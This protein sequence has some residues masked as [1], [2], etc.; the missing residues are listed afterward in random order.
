[1]KH[2]SLFRRCSGVAVFIGAYLVSGCGVPKISPVTSLGSSSQTA[3]S[4]SKTRERLLYSFHGT[5]DGAGPAGNLIFDRS[6]ALYGTT[7]GGGVTYLDC[8]AGCGTVFKL[9]PTGSGYAETILYRFLGQKYNDGG[10]SPAGGLTPA[11]GGVVFGTTTYGGPVQEGT[12]FE[13]APL[14]TGYLERV[15]HG[16]GS[17]PKDGANPFAGMTAGKNGVFYGTTFGGGAHGWGTVFALSPSSSG[18]GYTESIVYNFRGG[19]RDGAEPQA[20]V[21]VDANGALYGTTNG[22]GKFCETSGGACGTVFKLTPAGSGYS[23]KV[24]HIFRPRKDGAFPQSALL[25]GKSRALYGTTSEWGPRGDCGTIFELLPAGSNYTFRVLHVFKCSNGGS[26][27]AALIADR[28][29]T[30]FGTAYGRGV[31]C[32]LDQCGSVFELAPSGS[33]YAYRVLWYFRA[34]NDGTHPG[35]GLVEDSSG[36]LYGTTTAGGK[37]PASKVGFGTVFKIVP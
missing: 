34:H 24:L 29:G 6:G 17:Y 31:Y 10:D 35:G 8:E 12:I 9:T 28:S 36:A 18:D 22:G 21:T 19:T 33:G 15:V 27:E 32:E 20:P 7:S 2:F 16:F 26:P 11:A 1:M 4:A 14:G 25:I 5:P 13:L 30:L 3:V 23:E 37:R